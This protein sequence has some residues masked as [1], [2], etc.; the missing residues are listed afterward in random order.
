MTVG[1]TPEKTCNVCLI[2]FLTCKQLQTH[3]EDKHLS[4]VSD[5]MY[6]NEELKAILSGHQDEFTC[7]ICKDVVPGAG[8]RHNAKHLALHLFANHEWEILLHLTDGQ[9]VEY[10]TRTEESDPTDVE[11]QIKCI[12]C[13]EINA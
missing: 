9:C 3:Y 10:T 8:G 11:I 6:A 13:P 5:Y 12:D 4:C 2:T 1:T 7:W